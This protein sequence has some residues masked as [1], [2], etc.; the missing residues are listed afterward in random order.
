MIRMMDQ[1]D[2]RGLDLGALVG[3]L[4][5]VSLIAGLG[6]GLLREV[7]AAGAALHGLAQA[8]SNLPHP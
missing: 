7:A 1:E 6:I 4:V 3:F 2:V 5:R 8:V